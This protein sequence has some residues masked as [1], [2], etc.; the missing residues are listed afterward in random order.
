MCRFATILGIALGLLVPGNALGNPCLPDGQFR[1]NGG[2]YKGAD[3]ARLTDVE[4]SMYVAGF[5]NA[6]GIVRML[7]GSEVCRVALQ[8]CTS[9]RTNMQF[10]AM[11]R[12]HLRDNPDKWHEDAH[13]LTYGALF[14]QCLHDQQ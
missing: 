5:V 1:V 13:T 11:I 12:K 3:L 9:E 8:K 4:L 10:V 14:A 2:F 6:T 7:A